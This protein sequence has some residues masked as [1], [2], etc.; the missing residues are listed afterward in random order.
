MTPYYLIYV[1][2][3]LHLKPQPYSCR[4]ASKIAESISCFR[5]TSSP[6][7]VVFAMLQSPSSARSGAQVQPW[8]PIQPSDASCA[9]PKSISASLA[10][11]IAHHLG[12][13]FISILCTIMC[14][15]GPYFHNVGIYY[16]C[17]I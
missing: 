10:F 4:F 15:S 6:I 1:L 16:V 8:L 17:I 11:R 3:D 7:R 13:I 14:V 12:Y 5:S 9:A 2:M